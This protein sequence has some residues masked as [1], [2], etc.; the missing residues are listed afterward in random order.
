VRFEFN[1]VGPWPP[2][3]W[4][5]KCEAGDDRVS[6]LHGCG[7]ETCAE[8]FCEAVWAGSYGDGDFDRTDIVAG[9]GGRL[10]AEGVTFVGSGNVV[11]RLNSYTNGNTAWVSNS[12]AC[13]LTGIDADVD[14]VYPNYYEDFFSIAHGLKKYK[15]NVHT[16]RGNA[17]L[18]YFDNLH[19]DGR[20]LAL[21]PK[22]NTR[23]DFANFDAYVGFLRSAL[24]AVADNMA[25]IERRA[26]YSSLATTSTGYDAPMV[27]ALL[28]EVGCK[29]TVCFDQSHQG[30]NDSGDEIAK[31]LKVSPRKIPLGGWRSLPT[32]E[33]AFLAGNSIGEE[34]RFKSA[35]A[36]LKDRVLFTGYLGD[37][38]WG[39]DN[40]EDLT[41]DY[42]RTD[43]AGSGFTEYRLWAR[44][45]HCPLP[46]WGGRQ[47]ADIRNVS[48]QAELNPWRLNNGYDRPIPRR[49]LEEKGVPRELF[50]IRKRNSSSFLHNHANYLTPASMLEFLQW[51]KEHQSEW[52]KRL[53]IPP[54]RG[55]TIDQLTFHATNSLVDW[56]KTLPVIWKLAERLESRPVGVRRHVFPWAMSIA[57]R[58]YEGAPKN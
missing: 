18:T 28:A 24:S 54:L 30:E 55:D 47:V 34:L 7:V 12:L 25:A 48:Q 31:I 17:T 8:F 26:P 57:K 6:V 43:C 49:I 15:H 37:K 9:S 2:N 13:L 3:A 11:D 52:F 45:I 22:P 41:P 36:M 50:G 1:E 14:I 5:A 44:F 39:L 10:R 23:R 38:M 53:K 51:M 58:R 40:H 27:T 20:N 29:E 16:G 21:K 42:V 33:P 4:L 46:C 56:G 35:E 32:P 19:W